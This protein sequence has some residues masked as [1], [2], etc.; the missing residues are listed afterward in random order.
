MAGNGVTGVVLAAGASRRLGRPK[1][2][3]RVDGVPLVVQAVSALAPHCDRG[4]ICVVGAGGDEVCAV[5]DGLDVTVVDNPEW[6]EG[7]AAS[8]RCGVARVPADARSI[9]LA[10]CDQPRVRSADFARLVTAGCAA[11]TS[12]V[13]AGYGKGYG[14]PALFPVAYRD[15][16]MALRGD[17]GAK[18][19]IAGAAPRRVVAMPDAAFDVDRRED[20]QQLRRPDTR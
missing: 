2:L 8:I 10:L 12:V 3:V 9:L 11:P 13:A 1:Q 19:I 17:C 4:V 14:V 18:G 15:A 6:S 7:I 5:L 20:L 16:L